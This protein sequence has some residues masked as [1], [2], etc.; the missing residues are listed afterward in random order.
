MPYKGDTCW[1]SNWHEGRKSRKAMHTSMS[2]PCDGPWSL[3]HDSM[4]ESLLS[5]DFTSKHKQ[6]KKK[7]ERYLEAKCFDRVISSGITQF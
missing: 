2:G 6:T 7:K 5:L 3:Q 1:V 4:L